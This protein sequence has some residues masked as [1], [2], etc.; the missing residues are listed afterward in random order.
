M[1]RLSP[2][3]NSRP[4]K[5]THCIKSQQ[6]D[7]NLL[8]NLFNV[9]DQIKYLS[10]TK[11]GSDWLQSL[12]SDKR[13]ILYFIQPSTRTFLSFINACYILG[14]KVSD[15]RN[16]Q[17]SSEIKGESQEDTIRTFSQYANLII[18]RHPDKT[19]S[20]RSAG[21]IDNIG[22]Q[23]HVINAGSGP[24]QHPTQALLDIYTLYKFKVLTKPFT[25][26]II[27]DLKRGRAVKSLIYMITNYP[28]VRLLLISPKELGIDK[29]L[30][31][32]IKSKRVKYGES[33][34]LKKEL[35]NIDVFYLTR[36]QDEYDVKNESKRIN[37]DDYSLKPE[38]LKV[39]KKNALILHPLPRRNELPVSIDKDKRAV[40]WEQEKNG[41]WIRAALISHIFEKSQGILNKR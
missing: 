36:I 38:Y 37:Y 7:R 34:D 18:I 19:L 33:N 17:L 28:G 27:G 31:T 10:K 9:A 6:F 30:K 32:Y 5:L 4:S 8:T 40:Y 3:T 11:T 14:I 41:L 39:I 16:T 24:E 25:I 26:G 12:L 1:K 35:K 21:L 29:T 23:T 2:A 15:V 13:A 20:E 22:N